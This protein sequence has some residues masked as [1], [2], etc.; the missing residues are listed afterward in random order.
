MSKKDAKSPPPSKVARG[1]RLRALREA[2]RYD[3]RAFVAKYGFKYS[4]FQAWEEGRFGSIP[5]D[6]ALQ[7]TKI[8]QAEGLA[9]TIEWLMFDVG[10]NPIELANQA[11]SELSIIQDKITEG[12]R[13]FY[14]LDRNDIIQAIIKDDSLSP[15]Y[16]KG[17]WV[18]GKRQ[19]N[20]Q[21]AIDKPCIIKLAGG[22]QCIRILRFNPK[23]KRYS[24]ESD[25][26]TL[27]KDKQELSEN[28]IVLATPILWMR[29][30][31][32]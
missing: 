22:K 1:K 32:D 7:V 15:L 13:L 3:R 19:D 16:A 11:D 29:K 23:A 24:L 2:L 25:I 27:A 12:L 9:C 20:L 6:A 17:D 26:S 14:G 18:A 4:T 28:D 8:C 21:E 31:T 5:E 30:N 10:D